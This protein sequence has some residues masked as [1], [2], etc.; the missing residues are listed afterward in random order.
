[1]LSRAGEELTTLDVYRAA[2][3]DDTLALEVIDE[4]AR[5]LGIGITT[6]VHVLDPGVVVIGGAMTFGGQECSVGR[7][8]LAA[9]VEEFR[10]HTFENVFRGTTIAFAKLGADAGY[11][12]AAGYARQQRMMQ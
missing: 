1:L 10:Q 12:G 3:D 11:L 2:L 4:A 8:F 6:I 5:W 7:R 9:A